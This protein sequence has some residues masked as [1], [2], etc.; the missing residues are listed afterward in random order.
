MRSDET[1]KL[2]QLLMSDIAA[3]ASG[4][5]KSDRPEHN[6]AKILHLALDVQEQIATRKIQKQLEEELLN[7]EGRSYDKVYGKGSKYSWTSVD[8]THTRSA[9]IYPNAHNKGA[10]FGLQLHQSKNYEREA[11]NWRG[12][13]WHWED[14]KKAAWEWVNNGIILDHPEDVVRAVL[15]T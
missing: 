12:A 13:H 6:I 8:G 7:R 10:T 14:A 9:E 5:A 11:E 4:A 1:L 3:R 2:I 15:E